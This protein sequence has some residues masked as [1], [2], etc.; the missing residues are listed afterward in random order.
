MTEHAQQANTSVEQAL[1][2]IAG[3]D[4]IAVVVRDFDEG[5]AFYRDVMKLELEAIED[6]P[7]PGMKGAMFRAGETHIEI[8]APTREDTPISS[9]LEKRGGGVHHIA[10][11]VP[12]IIAARDRLVQAGLV[13]LAPEPTVGFGKSLILFFQPKSTMGTLTEIVQQTK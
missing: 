10:Y 7:K 1:D 12:D 11:R 2:G 13:P 3:V 4:H 6:M 9:F 8:L 5:L